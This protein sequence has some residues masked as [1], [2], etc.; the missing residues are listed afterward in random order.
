MALERMLYNFSST[1]NFHT[2]T[3]GAICLLLATICVATRILTGQRSN[4]DSDDVSE[5]KDVEV[6]PYFVPWL[7][8]AI[9]FGLRFQD[10]LAEAQY[11][12]TTVRPRS[13][14]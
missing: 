7:G 3:Y 4:H 10:F 12:R 8:S 5:A 9:S 11:V 1:P 2:L 14:S 6:V 13:I